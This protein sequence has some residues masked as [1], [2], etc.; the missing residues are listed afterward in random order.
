MAV[1]AELGRNV[2]RATASEGSRDVPLGTLAH[3]LPPDIAGERCDLVAVMAEVRPVLLDRT[4]DGPLVLFVDDLHRLDATSATLIA[5]LVDADLIF[6]VATVRSGEA[7]PPGLDSLWQRARVRRID[8]VDLDRAAVDT[9]LHLVL[10]GPV[11]ARTVADI[12][13]VSEGN[14]LFIREVVIGA[15]DTER[16]VDQ[17]GVWRLV[18]PFVTTP[19]LQDLIE[20]RL[21]ALGPEVAGVLDALAVWEPLGLSMLEAMAGGQ[22]LE[23][24]DRAG[25]L[26]V[27]T[28]GRRQEVTFA[29]PLYGEIL[30][31]RIPAL[32]RRRLLGELVDRVQGVGARRRE[33]AIRLA[34]ASL[35][36]TG[37]ADRGAVG[38]GGSAGSV[39][40]GLRP[41]RAAR[42]RRVARRPQPGARSA[43][44]GGAARTRGL[45]RG[46]RAAPLGRGRSRRITMTSSSSTS[47]RSTRGT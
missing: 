41:R 5:Q 43:G 23:E 34:T 42:P 26:A 13:E 37:S 25:I 45:R 15:V 29:H 30:R 8:L 39:R 9:L 33:D 28:D 11:E 4:S 27:R 38:P 3:L 20:S 6:L 19:R 31:D 46:R 2:A 24:L 1:A 22:P 17:R 40:A 16:L 12:W 10:G 18:G 21:R 32:T 36:A 47:P 35:E 7:V 14:V 44:G